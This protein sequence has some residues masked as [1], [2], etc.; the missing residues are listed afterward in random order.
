MELIPFLLKRF[1]CPRLPVN[2]HHH[3]LHHQ[4]GARQLLNGLKFAATSRCQVVNHHRGFSRRKLTLNFRPRPIG[5]GLFARVNHRPPALQAD[6]CTDGHGSIGQCRQSVKVQFFQQRD[7]GCA[8]FGQQCRMRC[9]LPQVNVN[10]RNQ[11]GLQRKAAKL[12][13]SRLEQPLRQRWR[14]LL[15]QCFAPQGLSRLLN[16]FEQG[17]CGC[18]GVC[19][20]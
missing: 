7:E 6:G 12:D 3:I 18:S 5:F 15:A 13:A 11:P 16:I 2:Q 20:S 17:L 8:D 19:R 9:Q 4:P 14:N 1:S 10:R